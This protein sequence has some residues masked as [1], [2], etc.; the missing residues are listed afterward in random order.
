[1]T[2]NDEIPKTH[3]SPKVAETATTVAEDNVEIGA[4][5]AQQKRR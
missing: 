4:M 1:V 3:Q 5:E 2:L